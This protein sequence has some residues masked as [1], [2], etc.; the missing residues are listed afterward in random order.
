MDV[1]DRLCAKPSFV[2]V[3]DWLVDVL[4]CFIGPLQFQRCSD[5]SVRMV[6]FVVASKS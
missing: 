1:I 6:V 3:Q 4:R 5:R 2:Y